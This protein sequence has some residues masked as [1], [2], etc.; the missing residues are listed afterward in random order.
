MRNFE[1]TFSDFDEYEKLRDMPM[2]YVL[3]TFDFKYTKIGM[4]KNIKQRMSNIQSG[5]PFTLSL[6]LGAHAPNVR[7]IE[8]Y[9]HDY[10]SSKNIRG[11]W[12]SLDYDDIDELLNFFSIL[13]R[14]VKK[15]FKELS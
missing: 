9:L 4:A 12:F 6:Y 7:D 2:V 14:E 8:K 15:S 10:F 13:N 1:Y 3:T 11:E 5:C